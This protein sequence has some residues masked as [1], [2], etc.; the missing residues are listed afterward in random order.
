MRKI[1]N[2]S[3]EKVKGINNKAFHLELL[4]NK[5]SLLVAP[6]G[7]GKSSLATAFNKLNNN[8]I[9][10]DKD[11]FYQN[12]DAN[13]PKLTIVVENDNGTQTTLVAEEGINTIKNQFDYF[14]VNSLLVSK[15]KKQ[16]FQGKTVVSS[17]IEITPIILVDKI[18]SRNIINYTVTNAKATFGTNGKV[19]PNI[20]AMLENSKFVGEL[21]STIDFS[22]FEGARVSTAIANFSASINQLTGNSIQIISSAVVQLKELKAKGNLEGIVALLDKH[23]SGLT[24]EVEKYL[25]AV[26]I[27]E[28]YK[29][30]KKA[31]AETGQYCEYL[32]EKAEYEELFKSLNATWKNIKPVEADGALIVQFPKANQISNG[33]R[34]VIAFMSQ[35]I[36][37]K[38]KLRKEN[39]ILI[40]DEVFDYLDD[41]NLITAQYYITTFIKDFKSEGRKIYP[42]IMTHLNPYYFK[43]FCF[44]DQKV[45]YLDKGVPHINR[46]IEKVIFERGNSLIQSNIDS[47]FLHYN[48]T[49][50]DISG[51]FVS[52]GLNAALG[53]SADFKSTLNGEVA[54]YLQGRTTFDPLSVCLAVRL[55]IEEKAYSSL[56]VPS[57]QAQFIA[58]HKTIN[59]LDFVKEKGVDIPEIFFLLGVVYNEMAHI[60]PHIDYATPIKSK[61]SNRIV[62]NMIKQIY[63]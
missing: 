46:D 53:K 57:D 48:P 40:I 39:S 49:D 1:K 56:T 45:Y 63:T 59:K 33:E 37:A 14:V 2:I 41:A 11:D 16:T 50:V 5:P 55:K 35:L 54:K 26:S 18:P 61:L 47:Y 51:D 44:S 25:S 23:N 24:N 20:S 32:N 6:N 60:K 42:L 19:L 52:I 17:S 29:Q 38:R 8:G 34:D 36:R 3:I 31:F 58:T 62:L 13:K 21:V 12:N 15:H 43:N 28:L 27:V 9:R 7:F 22:K 4:P 30:N 10:L